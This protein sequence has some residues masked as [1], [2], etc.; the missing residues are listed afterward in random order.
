MVVLVV[1]KT[2]PF[3]G[4]VDLGS[5]QQQPLNTGISIGKERG[6]VKSEKAIT[7]LGLSQGGVGIKATTL[8]RNDL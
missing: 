1:A 5:Y 7:K 4:M 6:C 8:A 2:Q 3:L